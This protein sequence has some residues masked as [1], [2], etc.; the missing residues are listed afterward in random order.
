M[1]KNL[2]PVA[3]VALLKKSADDRL[4]FIQQRLSSNPLSPNLWEFPGGKVEKEE[5]PEATACR[6]MKEETGITLQKKDLHPLLTFTNPMGRKIFVF[7][8]T[9]WQNTPRGAEGQNI[10]WVSLHQ[11][12]EDTRNYLSSCDIIFDALRKLDF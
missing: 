3:A 10:A 6:E 4:V 1:T 7:D 11:K 9:T 5:T 8:A 12:K 2:T